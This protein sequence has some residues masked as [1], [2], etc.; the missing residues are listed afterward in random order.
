MRAVGIEPLIA[1]SILH[2]TFGFP[3]QIRQCT[4]E[5]NTGLLM[6]WQSIDADMTYKLIKIDYNCPSRIPSQLLNVLSLAY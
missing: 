5:A 6:A 4:E 1:T 3:C 2:F